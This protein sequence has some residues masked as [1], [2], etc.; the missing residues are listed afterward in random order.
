MID[1]TSEF[2]SNNFKLLLVCSSFVVGIYVQHINNT[3]QIDALEAKY[4]TLDQKLDSPFQ[5]IDAIKL[6]KAVFELTIKQFS[7]MREDIRAIRQD[8]R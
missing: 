5:K 6:D 2:L 8:L 4:T 3:N 7:T 1:K